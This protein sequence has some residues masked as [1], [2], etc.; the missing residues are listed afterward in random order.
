M[1]LTMSVWHHYAPVGGLSHWLR[2]VLG[3]WVWMPWARRWFWKVVRVVAALRGG[4]AVGGEDACGFADVPFGGL[5]AIG[6]VGDVAGVDGLAAGEEVV[7]V[8]GDHGEQRDLVGVGAC[9]TAR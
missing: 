2:V 6:A 5:D 1:P 9:P 7:E 4:E 8:L 3:Q